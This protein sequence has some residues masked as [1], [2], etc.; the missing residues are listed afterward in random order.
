MSCLKI[1][2]S[3]HKHFIKRKLSALLIIIFFSIIISNIFSTNYSNI[4]NS[5][6]NNNEKPKI[7]WFWATLDLTNP[8]EVNNSVFTHYT[9]IS[10]KGRLYNKISGENKSGYNVAI[11]VNDIVDL[12]YTDVTD[13]NGQFDINYI[14]D[15]FLDVY[16]SHKIEVVVT[17]T[18]PGGPGSE[19]EYLH[20]YTIFANATSYFD[21][22]I[23]ASDDTSVA[24]LTEE[25][26]NVVGNLRFDNGQGIPFET[27]NYYWFDG[28]TIISQGSFFTDGSGSLTSL[29]VPI[30]VA[31]YLTLKFNY[32]N[33]PFV[34][35][36]EV[37]I[38]NITIF[39]DVNF[40]LNIDYTTTVGDIYVLTGTIS[41]F[42]D[43]SI[44]IGNRDLDIIFN[45]T[46]ITTATTISDGTFSAS[47]TVPSPNGS[48]SI[49][50]D[51]DNSAGRTLNSG[52]QVVLVENPQQSIQT[53]IEM[54]PFLIFSLIFFPILIVV[55]VGLA[56][57]GFFF[58]K[59]QEEE[60]RVA[61]IPLE[62]KILNLKILK[63]SGR[64]EESLSYLFNAIYM[65]LVNAKYNRVKKDNE[66]IRDFA[67]VS[68]KEL[69]LTPASIYPF[70]QQV[71]EIIYGKPFK[72]TE[73][74]FYKTCELF[75]PIY[76]QL[77]RH[78]FVLNF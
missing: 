5:H 38:S 74:D 4:E 75:S 10:V 18:E 3:E 25:V 29:Q 77:T 43:P 51:L 26:F 37:Y 48:A 42:T 2:K 58:Y 78:N 45:G 14:I 46:T 16:S 70:I 35:Y 12:S 67:I 34:G 72:I 56:V 69:K 20:F 39:S 60:S 49:Q 52:P 32:T 1:R 19:I 44:K 9:S 59:K 65:D 76:F 55:V 23:G 63:E 30:T 57:Y 33:A 53:P 27:V 31:S 6:L 62:S 21:I 66:T 50:V 54:P 22:N 47:F 71:E 40:G 73:E 41:S 11:E 28:P 15:E 7:S 8:G 68:V 61:A 36:N 17:D 64:L 24:K 13:P